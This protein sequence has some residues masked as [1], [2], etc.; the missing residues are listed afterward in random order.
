M[1]FQLFVHGNKMESMTK[2][3]P[4]KYLPKEYGG[5]NGSIAEIIEEWDKKLDEY[6]DYFRKMAEYGTDEKLR[7]GKAID[8][9]SMFGIDGSFRKLD[10]DW[11]IDDLFKDI[12]E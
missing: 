9:N 4:L 10:V 7:P 2:Q 6:R 3:I 1:G 5:E 12:I 11:L 8:F